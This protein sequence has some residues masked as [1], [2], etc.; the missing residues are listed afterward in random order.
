MVARRSKH[1]LPLEVKD[2]YAKGVTEYRFRMVDLANA[3]Q[4]WKLRSE[5]GPGKS[6]TR[7][8]LVHD[9]QVRPL[10]SSHEHTL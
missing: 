2:T 7:A 6:F 1:R 8:H 9:S 5:G 4:I 10:P 3:T